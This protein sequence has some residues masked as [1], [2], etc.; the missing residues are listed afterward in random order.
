M[1]PRTFNITAE[2]SDAIDGDN[3][4]FNVLVLKMTGAKKGTNFDFDPYTGAISLR[5]SDADV[6][7]GILINVSID[8]GREGRDWVIATIAIENSNDA[9][10]LKKLTNKEVNQ[11]GWLNFTL[12]ATDDDLD[13]GDSLSYYTNVATTVPVSFLIPCPVFSPLILGPRR[14]S[15]SGT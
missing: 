14:A 10:A 8:D 7:A 4:T 15:G 3:V 6:Q 13:S 1:R 11:F 12:G 2:G 5:P 9:P